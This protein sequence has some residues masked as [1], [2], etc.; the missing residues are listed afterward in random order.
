MISYPDLGSKSYALMKRAQAVMPGG[1]TRHTV[2][3]KPYPIYAV[4]GQGA[5]VEDVDGNRYLDFISN[6]SSLIH[7]HSFGPAIR[8]IQDQCAKLTVVGLP[9]ES[10]I[11]L[12]ELLCDRIASIDH[13]R[14]CN[15][16]TEA[17][18][19]GV[20][21]A[22]AYTGRPK[23][24]K[25]EGAYHGCY[26]PAEASMAPPA[27]IW[28]GIDNPAA[29]AGAY[30][31]PPGLVQD[32]VILPFNDLERTAA[33]LDRHGPSLAGILFDPMM[34]RLV[35]TPAQPAYV[36]LLRDKARQHGA[37]LIFDEVY[38]FRLAYNGA[39]SLFGITPDLTLLGKIIGG[40]MPIGAVGGRAEVMDVF[41]LASGKARVPQG[42]T[43]NGNPLA[44]AAGHASMT[45]LTPACFNH[46]DA[47]GNRLRAGLLKALGDTGVRGQVKGRGSLASLIITDKPFDN[48][49]SMNA[50]VPEHLSAMAIIH[51]ELLRRGILISQHGHFVLSTVLTE[52]D[53]DLA[54]Q[55]TAA[56][57]KVFAKSA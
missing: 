32:T 45:A 24:A 6:Y 42:G 30:G 9:T 46:L 17:V 37:L 13:I 15:S 48:Y 56:A 57:L 39:Q 16:G 12:A 49:R 54:I 21:A 50:I 36:E 43:F 19:F 47:L 28:G 52:A 7:G 53:I 10:E 1:N 5:R 11:A 2:F 23:I 20:K 26:D 34:S 3:F 8:A 55:Q 33:I 44:M 4:R 35:Y 31:T 27:D 18:M 40:G 51:P 14:F 29:V 25:I 22:R 38:S 41:N